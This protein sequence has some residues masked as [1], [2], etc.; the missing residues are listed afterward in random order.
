MPPSIQIDLLGG[1]IAASATEHQARMAARMPAR[2][3][4]GEVSPALS[5]DAPITAATGASATMAAARAVRPQE[6]FSRPRGDSL[7][8]S[9]EH[10]GHLMRLAH[11]GRGG[12]AGC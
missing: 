7:D 10:L 1:S 2:S 12:G 6:P 9:R 5:H 3:G 4:A 8:A 11:Y